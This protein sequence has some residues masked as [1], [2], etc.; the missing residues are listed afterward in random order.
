MRPPV[1]I[2]IATN[3][4]VRPRSRPNRYDNRDFNNFTPLFGNLVPH[5]PA[6]EVRYYQKFS[7]APPNKMKP[8][9]VLDY[10]ANEKD[11]QTNKKPP[12]GCYPEWQKDSQ[13]FK[14]V[15]WFVFSVGVTTMLV[16]AA[17]PPALHQK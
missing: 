12:V 6:S 15:K 14:K 1:R 8:P 2:N 4:Y 11:V 10:R 3:P 5:P 7:Q 13:P 9:A 17:I 16:F